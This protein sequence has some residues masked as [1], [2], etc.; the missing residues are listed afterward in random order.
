MAKRDE[1]Y[2]TGKYLKAADLEG[3]SILAKIKTTSVE[4][5]KGYDGQRQKKLILYFARKLKPFI[6]NRTNYDSIADLLGDDT[7]DWGGGEIEL[8]GTTRS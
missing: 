2:G 8:Y 1:I 4:E 3:E 7:D 5:L 6:C